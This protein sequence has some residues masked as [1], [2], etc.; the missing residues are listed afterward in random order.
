MIN[1]ILWNGERGGEHVGERG[2]QLL[3]RGRVPHRDADPRRAQAREGVT[4]PHRDAA[5]TQGI[6]HVRPG[7][8]ATG[9][10]GAVS[11]STNGVAG[12][13]ATARPSRRRPSR[14]TCAVRVDRRQRGGCLG[15]RPPGDAQASIAASAGLDTDHGG[16]C[17]ASRAISSR[18]PTTYPAR[19]P[20]IAQVLV[21]DRTTSRPGI[22]SPASDSASPGTASMNASSTTTTR[23]G[24]HRPR[25]SDR[26][27]QHPGRVGRVADHHQIG[28]GG[29][30]AGCSAKPSAARSTTRSTR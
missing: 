27:V 16:C 12:A 11:T 4:A 24:R 28:V 9:R 2:R 18:S 30:R 26:R 23:P 10:T 7:F 6:A 19:S 3:R 22:C 15:H 14:R 25:S 8:A 29:H 5:S 13:P 20:A 21:S 17:A 1:S